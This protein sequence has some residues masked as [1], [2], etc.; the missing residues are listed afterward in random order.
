MS[1]E[2]Q[3]VIDDETIDVIKL[4]ATI[5]AGLSFP[6]TVTEHPVED[7]SLI[8]DHIR[9]DPE[10]V[11]ITGFVSNTPVAVLGL[12]ADPSRARG[13]ADSLVELREKKELVR[14]TTDVHL[15][16]D[17]MMTQLDIPRDADSANALRFTAAFTKVTKVS[18]EVTQFPED[19]TERQAAPAAEL[20][21][22]T[23][24]EASEDTE[25]W[26]FQLVDALTGGAL[27]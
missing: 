22:Q 1:V 6:A 27:Q 20:G 4:D 9:N 24:T 21:K 16:N 8:A 19:D 10:T 7:G 5:T 13:A 11:T 25:S 18:T 3:R 17:M 15:F 23:T 14:I 26:A 12:N 2:I